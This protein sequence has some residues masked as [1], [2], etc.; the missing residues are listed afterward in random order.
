MIANPESAATAS[1]AAVTTTMAA[2]AGAISGVFTDAIYEAYKT[3]EVTYDLTMC[4]NGALAG[5]VAVTSGCATMPAW[6]AILVGIVGGWCY[7]LGSK[8]LVMLRIDDAVDAVSYM[9]KRKLPSPVKR[10]HELVL[11]L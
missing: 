10:T 1:L 11:L 2:A 6:A 3:G 7:I 4:M 9:A 8:A 5:L